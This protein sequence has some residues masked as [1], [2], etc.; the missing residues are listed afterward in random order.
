MVKDMQLARRIR[1]EDAR[2]SVRT[3][4][5]VPRKLLDELKLS[6][7]DRGLRHRSNFRGAEQRVGVGLQPKHIA[8]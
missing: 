4:S 5:L 7:T 3:M 8:N 6:V 2:G 1:G